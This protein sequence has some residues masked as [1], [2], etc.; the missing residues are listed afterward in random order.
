MQIM[1]SKRK[2]RKISVS[3]RVVAERIY[4]RMSQDLPINAKVAPMVVDDPYGGDIGEKIVVFRSLRDD[5]IAAMHSRGMVDQA[6]FAAARHWQRCYEQVEIGGA[7]AI[8]T[9]REAVDGGQIPEPFTEAQRRA[10]RDLARAGR[11]LGMEREAIVRDI[12]GAKR[13]LLLAATRRGL[14]SSKELLYFGSKFKESLEIL[15]LEFGYANRHR[16]AQRA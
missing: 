4:E 9:T 7:R 8:D 15:V 6:Q 16:E 2:M 13:T 3:N 14:T 1:A 5:P 11:A 10:A 12:L